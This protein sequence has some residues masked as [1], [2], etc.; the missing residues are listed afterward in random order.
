[1]A[2]RRRPR[3]RRGDRG[4]GGGARED[5]WAFNDEG[6]ARAVAACP[7]PVVSAVGHE[8]DVTICDLVADLRAATPSAAAE[9][10]VPVLADVA[11]EVEALGG[12]LASAATM[13]VARARAA[14][15]DAAS[16]LASA[17]AGMPSAAARRSRRSPGGCTRCHRSPRW[18]GATPS[19]ATPDRARRSPPPADFAPGAPFDLL[20]RDGRVRRGRRGRCERPDGRA[21]ATPPPCRGPPLRRR[22]HVPP[23][24]FEETLD[25]LHAIV[26]DLEGDDLQLDRALA[27]FE[28]G[29][30]R[31]RA[32]TGELARGRGPRAAARRD[33]RRRAGA[34]GARPVTAARP[35]RAGRRRRRPRRLRPP[36]RR[37]STPRSPAS[38]TATRAA[39]PLTADACGT[40]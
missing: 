36:A 27:L 4:R 25:R 32:A 9:A 23:V 5:L 6:L 1:V 12:A 11:A 20:V 3:L 28:E 34:G 21:A 17:A 26:A 8:V 29:V 31:L 10:V 39:P 35:P 7:L 30:E 33:R 19:P 2:R 13:Q 40:R 18:G 24:T 22:S 14:A 16:R 15:D 38:A 37:R